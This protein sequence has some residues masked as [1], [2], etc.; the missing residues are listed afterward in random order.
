M[1]GARR[2]A[3]PAGPRRA[4]HVAVAGADAAERD[5]ARP[6]RSRRLH[7][8]ARRL[9]ER[10]WP[11]GHR[12]PL[13]AGRS[14]RP[15]ARGA[16]A[17]RT[18]ARWPA[19]GALARRGTEGAGL[20]RRDAAR[21]RPLRAAGAAGDAGPDGRHR[22]RLGH[23]RLR[24]QHRHR[25]PRRLHRRRRRAA[26]AELSRPVDV[27]R[28][29]RRRLPADA[30]RRRSGADRRQRRQRRRHAEP[31]ALGDRRSHR[32]VDAGGDGVRQHAGRLHLRERRPAADRAPTTSS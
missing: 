25:A 21:E 22:L 8:R 2:R 30:A 23:G 13:S 11:L 1:D 20:G 31:A 4:R 27:E 6:H 9:R 18:L 19:P 24:R 15:P 32:R 14:H 12:Q 10:A 5:G 17:A 7:D 16:G 28:D 26:A 29:A 3:A